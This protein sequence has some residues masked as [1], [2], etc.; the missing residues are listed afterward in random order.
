VNLACLNPVEM[1]NSDDRYFASIEVDGVDVSS[2]ANSSRLF[3]ITKPSTQITF[4]TA[5]PV[6]FNTF[7]CFP[8]TFLLF[9]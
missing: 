3:D 6:L 7:Y 1:V 5:E 2:A 4:S 9:F 8:K